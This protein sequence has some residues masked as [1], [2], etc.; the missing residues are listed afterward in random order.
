MSDA[1]NAPV[2][3]PTSPSVARHARCRPASELLGKGRPRAEVVVVGTGAG[4]AVAGAE[5]QRAGHR[6]LFLEAGGAFDTKDFRRRSLLWS[7]SRMYASRGVQVSVGEPVILIPSGRGVGGST[8][9]NSGICFRP[10]DERLVEWS[11]RTGDERLLPEAMRPFVDEI[12]RRIGVMR[13]HPGIG[14]RHNMLFREGLERLGV[15]HAWMD[16]NAPGCIGCGICHL[17]CPSGGKASVDKAIL[18]EALHHGAEVRTRARVEGILIEGGRARGVEVAVLDDDD[19]PLGLLRVDADLVILAGSALGTP[20]ILEASGVERPG[21]GEHLA[22]HPGAG[23]VAE[24]D[25]P[26]IMWDGIPQGY[27]G[28]CPDDERVLLETITVGPAELFGLFGR[29]GS[30]GLR[31]AERFRFFAMGGGML[32]DEANGRVSLSGDK[33]PGQVSEGFSPKIRYRVSAR[34]LESMKAAMRA[35][36]RAYFL[37][38]ARRVCPLI[39]PLVFYERE[40]DALRAI[41]AV[42]AVTDLAHVHASHPHG[43]C[44]MGPKEGPYAG[45]VDADGNVHGIEGLYVMDG[46]IFPTT[47][48]VNPQVTIMSLSL[49]LARRLAGKGS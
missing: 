48:G 35:V 18:P 13:T 30:A 24:F 22:L 28:R 33:A 16:R 29:A 17:G 38:G 43:T 40:A 47:L 10:P 6:V 27:W 21:L 46:S 42:T 15:E 49:A 5:L 14:R 39:H 1:E 7:T 23:A 37:A 2:F 12:W 44:R 31:M 20:L 19:R 25:E 11:A 8:L 4:G 3:A 26:V 32:R 9:I 41:D 34:D 36:T 45:V